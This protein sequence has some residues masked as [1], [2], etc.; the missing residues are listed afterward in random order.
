[1]R[2]LPNGCQTSRPAPAYGGAHFADPDSRSPTV[3]SR[4]GPPDPV[5]GRPGNGVEGAARERGNPA[6]EADGYEPVS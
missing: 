5:R 1:M 4:D 3:T 2:E 6:E